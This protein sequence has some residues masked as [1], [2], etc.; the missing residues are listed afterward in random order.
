M[1]TI[2][3]TTPGQLMFTETAAPAL[4]AGDALVRV[5]RIGVCGTDL[6]A[7]RGRQPFFAYPRILGHELGVEIV[8][9]APNEF[10]L[11]PGDRCAVEPEL[12]CGD[13]LACRAGKTNCCAK[14][15]LIGVHCDGGMRELIT[16]PVNKL[17]RSETLSCDQ[18]ALVEPLSIGAHAVERA[19]LQ[20]G[21]CVLVIGA[22]PIGLAVIQFAQFK[23]VRLLVFDVN[24][25]RLAFCREHYQVAATITADEDLEARLLELT[26]GAMPAAVFD[27]TGNQASMNRAFNLVANGGRLIFVGLFQGDVTFHDPDF[28]RRELTVLSSRNSTGADFRR[29]IALLEA[30]RV[31]IDPWITHRTS[32]AETVA[33][34]PGWLNPQAGFIKGMIEL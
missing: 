9:V 4:P 16:M 23:N 31:N 13:C 3:L 14:L 2:V 8:D 1:K 20:A 32:F 33:T 21:E 18:L 30:G 27:A 22:G 19:Q 6:N 5:R 15:Q 11:R 34:F 7:F 12:N 28:H 29:V 17:H 25:S 24:E 26:D 10:G